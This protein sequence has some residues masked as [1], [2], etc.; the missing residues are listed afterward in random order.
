MV[1]AFRA[2]IDAKR[3]EEG[4]LEWLDE[5]KSVLEATI[6]E[7]CEIS[8]QEHIDNKNK[9]AE[10]GRKEAAYRGCYSVVTMELAARGKLTV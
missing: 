3:W 9:P 1:A 2:N 6:V 7:M 5:P 8:Q 10:V 4:A